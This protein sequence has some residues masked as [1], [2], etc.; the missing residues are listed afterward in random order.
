[1]NSEKILEIV[2]EMD[3]KPAAH[4]YVANHRS[5]RELGNCAAPRWRVRSVACGG[6]PG[7]ARRRRASP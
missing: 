2:I 3:R 6:P 1:M 5:C 7:M 4:P